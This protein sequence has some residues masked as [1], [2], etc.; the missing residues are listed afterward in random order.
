MDV[1]VLLVVMTKLPGIQ[2]T[3]GQTSLILHQFQATKHTFLLEPSFWSFLDDHHVI[4][5]VLLPNL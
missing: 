2:H 3:D 4:L 5:E 1:R